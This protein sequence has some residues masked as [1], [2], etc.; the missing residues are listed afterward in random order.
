MRGGSRPGA[1]RK[2]GENTK[3]R[4]QI[5]IDALESGRTPLD[6]ILEAMRLAYD[7]GGAA[8]AVPFAKDAAPY[9]HPKLANIEAKLDGVIGQYT[10]QPIPVEERNSDALART[11]RPATNG[12]S[13]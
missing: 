7:S 4:E 10:A 8:A 5:A 1:G 12:H 9:V 2:K 6:I 13:V 3:K 11:A